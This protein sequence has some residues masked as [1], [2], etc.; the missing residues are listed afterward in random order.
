MYVLQG[1]DCKWDSPFGSPALL[2]I[3]WMNT[4]L[5]SIFP[6][7]NG[8]STSGTTLHLIDHGIDTGDVITHNE[9]QIDLQDTCRDLYFKY[10]ISVLRLQ[11][12]IPP[13][14]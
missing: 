2:V 7:L 8:E 13:M 1:W 12:W 11:N 10:L 6:I 5:V 14:Q 9:F 3:G 4:I